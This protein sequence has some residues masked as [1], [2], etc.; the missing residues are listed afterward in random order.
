MPSLQPMWVT[1]K[2]KEIPVSAMPA[3]HLKNAIA[4]LEAQQATLRDTISSPESRMNFLKDQAKCGWVPVI[5]PEELLR[6]SQKWLELLK[7]E[8]QSRQDADWQSLIQGERR[9]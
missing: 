6:R 7:R 1:S 3:P 2:G 9:C 8:Q 5:T 4:K